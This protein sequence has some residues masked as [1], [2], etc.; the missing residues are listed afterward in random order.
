MNMTLNNVLFSNTHLRGS[1][2]DRVT[3]NDSVLDFSDLSLSSFL[4]V[5]LNRVRINGSNFTAVSLFEVAADQILIG[6]E[7]SYMILDATR[8]D[9][10]MTDLSPIFVVAPEASLIEISKQLCMPKPDVGWEYAWNYFDQVKSI[11]SATQP[12]V[13]LALQS[14]FKLKQCKNLRDHGLRKSQE[15]TATL[16]KYLKVK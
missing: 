4:A 13:V 2:W 9:K 8:S 10:L 11:L 16:K 12:R 14:L 6:S 3:I 5:S 7:E 1:Y 15:E